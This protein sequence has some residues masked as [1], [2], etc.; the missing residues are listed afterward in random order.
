VNL[1]ILDKPLL[2]N[3]LQD[4]EN[5]AADFY[6]M[7]KPGDVVGLY[8]PLGAGKTCFVRGV[9]KA[10]GVDDNNIS[11]PS[12]TLIN[13]YRGG[14]TPIFHFD[15]FRLGNPSEFETLGADEYFLQEGIILIEW[16]EHAEAYLPAGRYNVHFE[17]INETDRILKI[18]QLQ[19]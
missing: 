1:A 12:F 2:S 11:S 13:E 8:G 3:S 10:A 7:I 5:I 16:A 18:S 6:K 19:P 9:A 14:K 15:L 4:T 17:I